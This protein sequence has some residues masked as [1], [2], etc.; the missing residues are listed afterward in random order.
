MCHPEV[1]AGTPLPNVRTEEVAIDVGGGPKMSALLALPQRTPAPAVLVVNDVFGRVAFYEHLSRRL[2]QAGFVALNPEFFFREG[3]LP[4]QTREAALARRPK[5]NEKRTLV[6]LGA[7]IDWLHRRP[8]VD[9]K[10]G[11]IGFCMG[12]TFVLNLA[13]QRSDLAATVSYYGFP[14][15]S[16]SAP[17]DRP[18]PLEVADRMKGPIL[19]HWGDQDTG[20]G[21][22]NVEKLHARLEE[23]GFS[24]DIRIYPGLG[25]GFLK[26]FL[27]DERSPGYEQACASWTRTIAFYREAFGKVP[28]SV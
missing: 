23:T 6:D 22:E 3:P 21:M 19:G 5:L 17:N 14:A 24:H 7:A 28:A 9:G 11:T 4:E 16:T 26:A 20:V 27:E 13:A 10:V 25:H 8:D 15:S 12:G 2:G 1:P 18:A